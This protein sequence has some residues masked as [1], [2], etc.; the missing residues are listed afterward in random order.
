MVFQVEKQGLSNLLSTNETK[1]FHF[2]IVFIIFVQKTTCIMRM[3][4]LSKNDMRKLEDEVNA[5]GIEKD[6][7]VTVFKSPDGTCTVVYYEED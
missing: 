4:T 7:I 1:V 6:Q 3:R 5:R 2:Q